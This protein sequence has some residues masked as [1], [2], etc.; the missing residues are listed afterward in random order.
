MQSSNNNTLWC[1]R[2]FTNL[3]RVWGNVHSFGILGNISKQLE[4]D[5]LS[6]DGL[7]TSSR[8]CHQ[9]IILSAV[10]SIEHC[11]CTIKYNNMK[12]KGNQSSFAMFTVSAYKIQYLNC[13][14]MGT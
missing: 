14:C 4:D 8:G 6:T 12:D 5:K 2:I 1:A 13:V 7:T 11:M 10:Q 9:Y 3:F